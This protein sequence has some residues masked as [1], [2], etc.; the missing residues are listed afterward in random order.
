MLVIMYIWKATELCWT[1]GIS[2]CYLNDTGCLGF[3]IMAKYWLLWCL[4]T[5]QL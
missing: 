5:P 1:A 3:R 4:W 2:K